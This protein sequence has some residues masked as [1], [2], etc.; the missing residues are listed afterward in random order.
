MR[1][2]SLFDHLLEQLD[3]SREHSCCRRLCLYSSLTLRGLAVELRLDVDEFDFERSTVGSSACI[4][5]A[6][7]QIYQLPSC[8]VIGRWK[9]TMRYFVIQLAA[10]NLNLGQDYPSLLRITF[11]AEDLFL[12]EQSYVVQLVFQTQQP[13]DVLFHR[14]KELQALDNDLRLASIF[15]CVVCSHERIRFYYQLES[16]VQLQQALRCLSRIMLP[17]YSLDLNI[18]QS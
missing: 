18:S 12:H 9:R 7:S 11:F 15:T 17:Y 10:Q 2:E 14:S 16:E 3:V 5:W 8:T 6:A 13:V 4:Y 1:H